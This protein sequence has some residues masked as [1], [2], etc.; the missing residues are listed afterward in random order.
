MI[1]WKQDARERAAL[2]VEIFEDEKHN[3]APGCDTA[4]AFRTRVETR[5]AACIE[6]DGDLW[7]REMRRYRD[8]RDVR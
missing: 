6:D 8:G 5:F 3:P 4:A 1:N 2:W 7:R